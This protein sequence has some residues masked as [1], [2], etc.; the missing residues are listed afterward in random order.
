MVIRTPSC[1]SVA[2]PR[3][4]LCLRFCSSGSWSRVDVPAS[5]EPSRPIAPA[6]KSIASA[7][8]VFPAPPWEMRATLRMR[9]GV[10]GVIEAPRSGAPLSCTHRSN[11][12]T[13]GPCSST[14]A[15]SPNPE[16]APDPLGFL[17]ETLSHASDVILLGIGALVVLGLVLAWARIRPMEEARLRLVAR[18]ETYRDY[19]PW[20]LRLSFGLV[21]LGAGMTRVL[22]APDVSPPEWP[23]LALSALGFLLLLGLAVRPGGDRRSARLP[24]RAGV[25]AGAD[26]DLGRG[27]RA[28]CAGA[29]GSG[30]AERRRSAAPRLPARARAGAP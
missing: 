18:A 10:V 16:P 9:S 28:G 13:I 25:A 5:T 27:R 19:V 6:S 7:R 11:G 2:T 17:L 23:Y 30:P 21:L 24:G 29:G 26:R 3:S 15:T 14:S 22:F 12:G 4:M 8:L 20:M 1:S